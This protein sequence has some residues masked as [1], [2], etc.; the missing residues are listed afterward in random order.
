MLAQRSAHYWLWFIVFGVLSALV[1]F[2][3]GLGLTTET[4]W[5]VITGLLGVILGAGLFR[6]ITRP[7]DL[8]VGILFTGIGLLGVLHN[9][10]INLVP[11]TAHLPKGTIDTASILGLSLSLPYALIHT[12]LGLTSLN[13]G[14]RTSSSGSSVVVAPRAAA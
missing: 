5:L 13:S 4:L 10:D 2:F 7:Y 11:T 6:S 9:F 8:V 1:D 12:L 3:Q 14:L